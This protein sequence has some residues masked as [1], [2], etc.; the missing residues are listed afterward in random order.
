MLKLLKPSLQV[1][2]SQQEAAAA[3]HRFML[4]MI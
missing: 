2:E 1:I 4:V 3:G